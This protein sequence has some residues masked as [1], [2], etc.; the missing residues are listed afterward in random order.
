MPAKC[1]LL[2]PLVIIAG[3]VMG[4]LAGSAQPSPGSLGP[5]VRVTH[6]GLDKYRPSWAPNGHLILFARREPD[7]SH[8]SQY[9]LDVRTTGAPAR[10]LTDRK[11]PEYNGII[12]PDG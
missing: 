5:L 9:L 7:G 11:D 1:L 6:D 10:R 3:L 12:S 2:L 4:L 8:I